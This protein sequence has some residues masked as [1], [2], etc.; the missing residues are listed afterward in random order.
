MNRLPLKPPSLSA[1]IDSVILLAR[2]DRVSA[3][4]KTIDEA[5]TLR[6]ESTEQRLPVMWRREQLHFGGPSPQHVILSE[7]FGNSSSNL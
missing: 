3:I 7:T 4:K 1:L 2:D 5:T 6:M